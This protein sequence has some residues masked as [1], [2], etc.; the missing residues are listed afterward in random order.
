MVI[1]ATPRGI[2]RYLVGRSF[3]IPCR[4]ASSTLAGDGAK[5][6]YLAG[7]CRLLLW[8]AGERHNPNSVSSQH[9]LVIVSLFHVGL[10]LPRRDRCR[11]RVRRSARCPRRSHARLGRRHCGQ[12]PAAERIWAAGTPPDLDSGVTTFKVDSTRSPEEWCAAIVGTVDEHH[13]D[14]SHDPPVSELEIYGTRPTASL[15]TAFVAYGFEEF[16]PT[17]DGFR[18]RSRPAS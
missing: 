6:P 14:F 12:P 15:Q 8:L 7:A 2:S 16:E 10:C 18:A 9:S 5:R 1:P 11:S 3:P 13:G 4:S 17:N